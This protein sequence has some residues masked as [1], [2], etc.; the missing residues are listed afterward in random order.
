M[1]KTGYVCGALSD[2]P[3]EILDD[4]KWFYEQIGNVLKEVTGIEPFVPHLHCDPINHSH[5][6]PQEIDGI[7][8][9]QVVERTSILIAVDVYPS[10]GGG[11][12]I[13]I[14][15]THNIPVIM[16][17]PKNLPVGKRRSRLLYGNPAI[18]AILDFENYAQGLE[19][20]RAELKNRAH[21]PHTA[22]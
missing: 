3:E 13:E 10:W 18:V 7:E 11:I 2:L 14:C 8:R 4:T 6:T 20:L 15:N 22:S 1:E 16:M 12:E 19:L 9:P 17:R 21:P 5:F